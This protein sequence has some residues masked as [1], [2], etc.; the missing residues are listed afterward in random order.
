MKNV[1]FFAALC[2]LTCACA[3]ENARDKNIIELPITFESGFGPFGWNY[4]FLNPLHSPDNPR[5]TP[6]NKMYVPLKGIPKEW[7]SVVKSNIWLD[8]YQLLYQNYH[9]GKVDSATFQQLVKSWEWTPDENRLSKLPIRCDVYVVRGMDKSGKIAVMI[10]TNNDR[11]FSDEKPFYPEH[12][13]R[14]DSLKYYE[15]THRIEYDILRNRRIAVTSI[16]MIVK[17]LPNEPAGLQFWYTFPQYAKTNLIHKQ[18]SHPIAINTGFSSPWSEFSELT[19]PKNL[20][21]KQIIQNG[22]GIPTGSF[23]KVDD[24]TYKN[25]GVDLQQNVL[26]LE[27]KSVEESTDLNQV[28]SYIKSFSTKDFMTNETISSHDYKGKYLFIDFWGTWCQPCVAEL[29]ELKKLYSKLDTNRIRFISIAGLEKPA[30]LKQFLLKAPMEWP[31]ILSDNENKLVEMY[32]IFVY[33]SNILVGPDGKII[34][35]NI[36]GK[37][38]EALLKNKNVF[39]YDHVENRNHSSLLLK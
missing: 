6:W 14:G 2:L 12:A 1:T 7:K 8:S 30:R 33:P 25:L 18:K 24:I 31:Q 27:R 23:F 36:H 16:Q 39:N 21:P 15:N 26:R 4:G 11:D 34:G 35:K 20:F 29:P 32:H 37:Q 22:Q 19:L 5:A 3:H 17:Y 28:G 13:V 9:E 38:L 10:D